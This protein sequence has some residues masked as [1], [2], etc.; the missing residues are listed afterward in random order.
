MAVIV[1]KAGRTAIRRSVQRQHHLFSPAS[2]R[3]KSSV[4]E[5]T[6]V[7]KGHG[8]GEEGKA[9]LTPNTTISVP[10]WQRLGL[11]SKVFSAYGRAQ[12]TKPYTT[13]FC[14]S[15]AIYFCGDL[16]AQKLGGDKYEPLRSARNMV[17]GGICAIP[18][19]KW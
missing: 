7:E 8:T 9:I 19:Y 2:N 1:L 13:Q 5:R 12:R 18:A 11:L 17:I 14:T 15:L 3:Q 10:L 4:I 6:P 16:S